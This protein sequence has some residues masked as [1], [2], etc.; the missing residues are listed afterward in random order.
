M[1]INKSSKNIE[2]DKKTENEKNDNILIY[3]KDKKYG[4]IST[5]HDEI[6]DGKIFKSLNSLLNYIKNYKNVVETYFYDIWFSFYESKYEYNNIKDHIE[7][8]GSSRLFS[9]KL[10][11]KSEFIKRF[12]NK[13]KYDELLS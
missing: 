11:I 2:I 3:L 1:D 12:L 7:G 10:F 6:Y 8:K 5:Q 13:E 9:I 4:E